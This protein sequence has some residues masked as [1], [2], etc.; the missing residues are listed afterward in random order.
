MRE[1][2]ATRRGLREVPGRIEFV[3][4]IPVRAD[5]STD[6]EELLGRPVR[7]DAPDPEERI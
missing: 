5:G 4:I 1:R 6:I 3:D 2:V 7:L